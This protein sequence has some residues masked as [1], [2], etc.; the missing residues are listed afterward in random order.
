MKNNIKLMCAA[1]A[2]LM[3]ASCTD[4]DVPVESQY[5]EY[6]S[7]EIAQEAKLSDIYLSLIHI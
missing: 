6:P 2:M 3:M 1:S 7:S 5:T 4:L